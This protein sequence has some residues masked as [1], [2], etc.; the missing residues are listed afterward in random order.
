[1]VSCD[2]FGVTRSRRKY[3]CKLVHTIEYECLCIRKNEMLSYE[4]KSGRSRFRVSNY[5]ASAINLVLSV[6]SYLC[7]QEHSVV[8]RG[9]LIAY[10]GSMTASYAGRIDSYAN[11]LTFISYC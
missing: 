9:I 3:T 4:A 7:R 1:M 10:Y 5:D 6:V 11:L 2:Y 8:V